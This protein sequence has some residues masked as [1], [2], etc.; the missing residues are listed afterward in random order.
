[1]QCCGLLGRQE[2]S[3]VSVPSS[4]NMYIMQVCMY[5]KTYTLVFYV[6]CFLLAGV[7]GLSFLVVL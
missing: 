4:I 1:M 6:L 2:K 5:I 7:S 3:I